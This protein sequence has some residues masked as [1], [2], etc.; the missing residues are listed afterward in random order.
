[1]ASF[2]F[3]TIFQYNRKIKVLNLHGLEVRFKDWKFAEDYNFLIGRQ[4]LVILKGSNGCIIFCY[5]KWSIWK[6][7]RHKWTINSY[8]CKLKGKIWGKL[9]I[10]SLSW[11]VH[12]IY[13]ILVIKCTLLVVIFLCIELGLLFG[14]PT[15]KVQLSRNAHVGYLELLDQLVGYTIRNHFV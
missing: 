10:L 4:Q 6:L 11:Y 7:D 5:N 14:E 2:D 3:N 12:R 9:D 8:T 13:L 15:A 1:M